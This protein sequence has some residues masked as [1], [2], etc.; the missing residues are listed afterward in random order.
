MQPERAL[1]RAGDLHEPSM[2]RHCLHG[3]LLA[4]GQAVQQPHSADLL[5]QRAVAGRSGM[6]E[7]LQRRRVFGNVHARRRT[8]QPPDAADVR[9]DWNLDRR[10]DLLESSMRRRLLRRRVRAERDEVRA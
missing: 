3:C 4:R 6:S 7:R 9:F 1:G 5:Q 10:D 2:R 8:V